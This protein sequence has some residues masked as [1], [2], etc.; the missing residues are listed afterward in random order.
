MQTRSM[1]TSLPSSSHDSRGMRAQL[2]AAADVVDIEWGTSRPVSQNPLAS[3]SMEPTHR[4]RSSR[5]EVS[6]VAARSWC[7]ISWRSTQR[8]RSRFTGSQ[9]WLWAP[10]ALDYGGFGFELVPPA[11][12]NYSCAFAP[13][14]ERRI[15]RDMPLS[16]QGKRE[17]SYDNFLRDFGERF[18]PGYGAF[19]PMTC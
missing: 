4:C 2:D 19:R 13:Q 15:C 17:T 6:R 10:I 14:D 7:G 8:P 11:D 9:R 3:R 16:R 1:Q 18:V 12:K 5:T